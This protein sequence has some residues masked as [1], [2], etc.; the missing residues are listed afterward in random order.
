MER[1]KAGRWVKSLEV[2]EGSRL[3]P[4]SSGQL[5]TASS[6]AQAGSGDASLQ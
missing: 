5:L 6:G 3:A 1:N 4:G 2:T